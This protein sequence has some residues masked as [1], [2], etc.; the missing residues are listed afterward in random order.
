MLFRKPLKRHASGPALVSLGTSVRT[1]DGKIKLGNLKIESPESLGAFKAG[2]DSK[3][4]AG[5]ANSRVQQPPEGRGAGIG[6]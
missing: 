6:D 5:R 4:A 1:P 2:T 3:Q